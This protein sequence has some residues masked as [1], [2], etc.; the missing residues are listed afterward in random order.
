MAATVVAEAPALDELRFVLEGV[1]ARIEQFERP[2]ST[3][4]HSL[5]TALFHQLEDGL[6]R[7]EEFE[8]QRVMALKA[9]NLK[10]QLDLVESGLPVSEV[11]AGIVSSM[12]D[13]AIPKP[14]FVCVCSHLYASIGG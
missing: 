7:Y 12:L 4:L 5:Y 13:L 1:F 14:L 11:I 8:T 6:M 9:W 3:S 10:L 2:A